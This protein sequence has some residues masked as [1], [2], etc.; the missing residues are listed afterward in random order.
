MHVSK[1]ARQSRHVTRPIGRHSISGLAIAHGPA[2]LGSSA[3]ASTGARI[4]VAHHFSTMPNLRSNESG[5]VGGAREYDQEIK[6]MAS[7]VHN[8]KVDS[9]LAVCSLR[10]RLSMGQR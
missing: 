5:S 4:G 7:Y 10:V 6:D 2:S 8:Y 1:L 9:D 3:K